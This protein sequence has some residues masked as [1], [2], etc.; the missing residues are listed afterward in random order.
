MDWFQTFDAILTQMFSFAEY[1]RRSFTRKSLK[2]IETEESLLFLY[3]E[4][5]YIERTHYL[6]R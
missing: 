6:Q 4:H 2:R 1:E 3:I 5:L